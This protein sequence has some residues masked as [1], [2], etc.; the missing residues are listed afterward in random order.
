VR[1]APQPGWVQTFPGGPGSSPSTTAYYVDWT[2]ANV[3]AGT[4]SGVI[5]LPGGSTVTVGFQ[6]VFADG[7]PGSLYNA[8]TNGGSYWWGFPATF[9]SDQV[10]NAPP[11][12]DILQL[13][14]GQ[15][16]IYRVTLSEPIVDPIMAITS[17]GDI[18]TPTTYV[19]DAP[20]P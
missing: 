8:Q 17:L 16:Q 3:R 4:A 13:V 11:D 18:S 1:E 20:F 12:P 5:T 2:S 15:N 19:F 9:V 7:S 14:G 6:A 10:T